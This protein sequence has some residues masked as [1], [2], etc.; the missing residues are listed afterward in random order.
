[1]CLECGYILAKI[2]NRVLGMLQ[3][4]ESL[5]TRAPT[6]VGC[7]HESHTRVAKPLLLRRGYPAVSRPLAAQLPELQVCVCECVCEMCVKC[8]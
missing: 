5:L 1:M 6:A 8:V 3:D 2:T 4:K 7:P